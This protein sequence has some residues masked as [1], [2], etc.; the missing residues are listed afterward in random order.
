MTPLLMLIAAAALPQLHIDNAGIS[1]SGISS[2]AD[3]AVQ[4]QVAFSSS[5]CGVGVFAGQAYHCEFTIC[6]T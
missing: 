4:M 2:G 1:I 5:I 6:H 3:M